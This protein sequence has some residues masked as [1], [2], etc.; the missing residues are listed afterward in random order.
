MPDLTIADIGI[1]ADGRTVTTEIR[2]T[3]LSAEFLQTEQIVYRY[4]QSVADVPRGILVIPALANLCPL[5]WGLG[6]DI[7]VSDLDRAFAAALPQIRDG[8]NQLY[9]EWEFAGRV[10]VS[11]P[12]DPPAH[13]GDATMLLFSGGVDSLYSYIT[14]RE[15]NPILATVYY[16]DDLT[17]TDEH[18]NIR[19]W[20]QSV[21]DHEDA[22]TVGIESNLRDLFDTQRL[23]QR[24]RPILP[25]GWW[26]NIQH[27]LALLGSCAPV[28]FANGVGQLYIAASYTDDFDPGW[29]SHPTID[30][31]VRWTGTQCIHDGF[32]QS[33]QAKIERIATYSRTD[34]DALPIR[35][36]WRSDTG[37]NCGRCE[38]CCRTILGLELAGLD[39]DAHGFDV[40]PEFFDIVR[41]GLQV[42]GWEITS[43]EEFMW[44]DL[45]NHT[46]ED[47]E[48]HRK[49][50]DDFIDWFLDVDMAYLREQSMKPTMEDRAARVLRKFPRPVYETARRIYPF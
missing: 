25:N 13:A 39:A 21:A 12:I 36:C 8:F 29:G 5:A 3:G 41:S 42:D 34:F 10:R 45:Q 28:A 44:E 24:F 50:M 15:E 23:T 6:V 40:P 14:H 1:S 38:K 26:P 20:I 35:A 37:L 33:R 19:A 22:T 48:Y 7:E 16:T 17:T 32:D 2:A 46:D 4:P 43:D 31:R 30:N 11:T 27:G 9:P 47:R 18:D 49:G